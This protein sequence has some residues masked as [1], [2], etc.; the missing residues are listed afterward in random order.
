MFFTTFENPK[1]PAMDYLD[2]LRDWERSVANGVIYDNIDVLFPA[3]GFVRMQAGGPKDH[4]ASP[5]KM[6]LSRPKT[7]SREKTVVGATDMK[8]REQGDW[9]N[10]VSVIDRLMDEYSLGSVFEV[11]RYIADRFNLEMPTSTGYGFGNPERERRI[12]LLEFLEDYFVWNLENNSGA[13]CRKARE[14]LEGR[15]FTGDLVKALRFGFVPGW[16]KVETYVTRSR[17]RFTREEL[18]QACHVRSGEGY[19]TVGRTH[20]LAIP[21]RC[22]G[23]LKGFLFRAVEDGIVPKYKANTGLD[24][25]SAFF[26]IPDNRE[27]KDI[28]VVEGEM[29]AITATAAGIRD[30]VAIGGADIS[31]ERRSQVFD[32]IGR[33]TRKIILC[34]DLDTGRDGKPDYEKRF[35]AVR[36][37][38]HTIFDVSPDF[39]Q[40]F[41]A[42]FPYP[43]DPDEF[44]RDNGADAFRELISGSIPWWE[45]LDRYLSVNG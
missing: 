38:L 21:Y 15:G 30:V 9:D 12:Q 25:K 31:G 10:A 16:D 2:I 45:Y 39:S 26:N 14:Y 43:A 37:S 5:L 22:G 1:E 35:R 36:R 13:A 19:T 7:P 44:I 40:V 23:E 8:F 34:P 17:W 11:Y 4:W 33:K 32:A 3:Y 41:V 27:P 28:I 42:R 20:V 24:R 18:D 29:D 6:D